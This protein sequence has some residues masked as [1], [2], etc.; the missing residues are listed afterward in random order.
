[1]TSTRQDLL[2]AI[3]RGTYAGATRYDTDDEHVLSVWGT[4]GTTYDL[5]IPKQAAPASDS[6][7]ERAAQ[8][9]GEAAYNAIEF[10]EGDCGCETCIVREILEAAWPHLLQLARNEVA[11][12]E[13]V[14]A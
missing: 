6:E 5:R 8:D 4:Q 2:E 1:M 11:T 3:P 9:A 7:L 12:S 14:P 13:A 10:D